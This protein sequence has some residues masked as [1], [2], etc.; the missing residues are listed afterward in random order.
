MKVGIGYSNCENAFNA[1]KQAALNAITQAAF[2]NADLVLAFCSGALD[3]QA[4]Y[5]GLRAVLGQDVNIF[6]GS[7]IGVITNQNLSYQGYP[8]AVAVLKF[9]DNYCQMA[10]ATGLFNSPFNAGEQLAQALPNM[11]DA[12]L[13]LLLYDSVKFS[14]S[15]NVAPVMNPSAPLLRGLELNLAA[16]LPVAGAGLLGDHGFSHTLQFCGKSIAQ[17]SA[18]ALV[19]G[20]NMSSYIGVMHGCQPLSSQRYT[21]TGIFGQFLYSLDGKPAVEVIDQAFGG[22]NWRSRS[23]VSHLCL[24]IPANSAPDLNKENDYSNRLISGV[25]PN[26]EGIILFEPD[27]HEGMEIQLMRRSPALSRASARTSTEALLQQMKQDGRQ[28]LIAIYMDCAGR[29]AQLDPAAATGAEWPAAGQED[30][31]EVQSLLN[32]ARIPL[33]GFYCG[34]EIAPQAGKSRGLDWSGVLIILAR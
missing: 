12:S 32:E 16:P 21:I 9:E 2:G 4:F 3:H 29:I 20:G 33:L 18:S 13:L 22:R 34:V 25:L 28:P 11:P 15:E 14:G 8:A 1:G 26:D 19:F 7:A 23:P 31:R 17:Q 24:G 27:M 30:A 5:R 6:G 10:V